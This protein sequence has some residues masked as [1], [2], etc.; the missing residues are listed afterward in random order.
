MNPQELFGVIVRGFGLWAIVLAVSA[1]NG[2]AQMY[3]LRTMNYLDWQPAG[4]FAALY[5]LAGFFAV[6]KADAI[7]KFAYSPTP[8]DSNSN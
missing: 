8:P 4:L 2:I 1:A 7:V 5:L 6:R 3:G